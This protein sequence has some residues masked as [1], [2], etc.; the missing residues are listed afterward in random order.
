MIILR[1][2]RQSCVSGHSSSHVRSPGSIFAHERKYSHTRT[3][4]KRLLLKC[5]C[6]PKIILTGWSASCGDTAYTL[7]DSSPS[8]ACTK[9]ARGLETG[10]DC[11][12]REKR[13]VN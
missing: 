5:Q 11:V 1:M 6:L 8:A 13:E 10:F 7:V 3:R 9:S 12:D 2:M 4:R